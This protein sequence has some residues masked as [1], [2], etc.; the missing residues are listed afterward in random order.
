MN[1]QLRLTAVCVALALT[2]TTA[3]TLPGN[4]EQETGLRIESQIPARES[5]RL[6]RLTVNGINFTE[7]FNRR[8]AQQG[9]GSESGKNGKPV[10]W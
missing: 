3:V 4:A 5:P 2:S 6:V 1:I 9:E 10:G 8:I 7:V